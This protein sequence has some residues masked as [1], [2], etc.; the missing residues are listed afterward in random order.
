MAAGGKRQSGEDRQSGI[1]VREAVRKPRVSEKACFVFGP[2][3]RGKMRKGKGKPCRQSDGTHSRSLFQ[4]PRIAAG[5][6]DSK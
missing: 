1:E 6:C 5:R 3:S 4:E 2:L